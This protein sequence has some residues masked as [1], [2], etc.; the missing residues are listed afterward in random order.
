MSRKLLLS[1]VIVIP[2]GLGSCGTVQTLKNSTA[3]M[4]A[5]L[6]SLPSLPGPG[7]FGDHPKVVKVREQDLKKMPLGHERALAFQKT[8][9]V[10]WWP[11]GSVKFEPAPLPEPGTEMDGSLLPPLT[12]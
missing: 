12:P 3:A 7:M 9:G 5:K 1:W 2:V 6:P 11:M 4:V 10:G 8:G